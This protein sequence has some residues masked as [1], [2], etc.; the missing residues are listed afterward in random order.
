M[1]LGSKISPW[2]AIAV[3]IVETMENGS[4]DKEDDRVLV[5]QKNSEAMEASGLPLG[6]TLFQ[7]L[8]KSVDTEF[9]PSTRVR[10]NAAGELMKEVAVIFA[11]RVGIT[12]AEGNASAMKIV[13]LSIK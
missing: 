1:I 12:N 6:M 13:H 9:H 7:Q 4:N 2:K 3:T 8:V 11:Q 10:F 5:L